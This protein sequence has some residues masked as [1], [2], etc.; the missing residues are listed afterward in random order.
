MPKVYDRNSCRAKPWKKSGLQYKEE[1]TRSVKIH[2][3]H[4]KHN[5]E[6]FFLTDIN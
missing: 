5:A 4:R 6:L 2:R 1:I 3:S